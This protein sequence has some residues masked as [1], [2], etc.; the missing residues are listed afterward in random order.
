MLAGTFRQCVLM[1]TLILLRHGQSV[2]N[3]KH[4]FTGWSD[5]PLT[6]R[7]EREAEQAG[8]LM[9]EA[10]YCIDACFTSELARATESVRLIQKVMAAGQ[11]PVR[12]SWRFNERCYGALEG[13]TPLQALLRFGPLTVVRSMHRFQFAPPELDASDPRF[14]GNDARYRQVPPEQLPR[15]ESMQQTLNR[16]LPAWREEVQP[17]LGKGRCV[18]IVSHKNTLRVLMKYLGGLS[19]REAERLSIPTGT[20]MVYEFDEGLK[21]VRQSRLKAELPAG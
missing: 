1:P 9:R 21:L 20:P 10:G 14:P 4:R 7:G 17:E 5:V 12:R 18:L 6:E 8:R 11:A 19:D 2:W 15:G 16:L 13:L 3:H